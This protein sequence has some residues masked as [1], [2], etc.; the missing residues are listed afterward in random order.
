MTGVP[1]APRVRW[2]VMHQH[3]RWLTFL[4]WRYPAD[5]VQRLLPRGLTVETVDGTA[6]VGL[7][8]FQMDA[9]RAPGAPAL[10]WLSRFPETNVRTYVR[11]PDGS[12][13][14]WF[15]SLDADRLSAVVTGR[16]T[17]GLPYFWSSMSVQ[18]DGDQRHYQARRR[19]PGPAGTRG[20]AVVE[21]GEPLG[22]GQLGPRDHFLTA[23]YRLFSTVAGRLVV[24]EAEHP[25]WQLRRASVRRLCP[26]LVPA[27]G[28]PEPDHEPVVHASDGVAV[29]IGRWRR[30]APRMAA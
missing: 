1:V 28:L 2:P 25:V 9:V 8:P 11:G 4:H 6:W 21:F 24:A 20:D 18:R 14:I 22:A 13:G 26:D 10:P 5:V 30:A 17:Y 12:S 29:R 15:L 23:R 27:A 7:V 19:W 16:L 3:W